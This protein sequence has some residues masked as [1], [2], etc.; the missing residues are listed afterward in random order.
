MFF[1]PLASSGASQVK[2]KNLPA[3]ARDG[4]DRSSAPGLGRSPGEGNGYPLQYLYLENSTGRGTCRAT[5]Q[6][7][8]E[9]DTTKQLSTFTHSTF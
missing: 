8:A 6:G 1:S 4:R 9:L 7:I 5:V 3:I 2:V